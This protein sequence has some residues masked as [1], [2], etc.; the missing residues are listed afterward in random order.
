L[1]YR[2]SGDYVEKIYGGPKNS[3][4]GEQIYSGYPMGIEASSII[5][6]WQ[7]AHSLSAMLTLAKFAKLDRRKFTNPQ[8]T[9]SLYILEERLHS[10]LD[11]VA[12]Y[13]DFLNRQSLRVP[14]WPIV[15]AQTRNVG[16][17]IA[18]SHGDEELRFACQ[19]TGQLLRL[20]IA[21]VDTRLLHDG[22]NLWMHSQ[23]WLGACRD[24]FGLGS[25]S[26]LVEESSGHL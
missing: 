24:S 17:L 4:T 18:A 21:E 15:S 1:L 3:R 20:S 16:A 23:S 5:A 12:Y 22:K 26:K 9:R 14:K 8:Q 7:G 6:P 25:V 2:F 13:P 10:A 19:V 11:V